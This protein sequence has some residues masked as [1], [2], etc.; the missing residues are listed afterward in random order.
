MKISS[1]IAYGSGAYIVHDMLASN[2]DNYTV[3][4]Y[5]P[6]WTYFPP[7]IHY[8]GDKS[9]DLVHVPIDYAIF[10]RLP[11][12]PLISTF[13]SFVLDEY[14]QPYLS[15]AQKI[16]YKTDLK[17]FTKEALKVSKVVT[18]VSHYLEGM[19]K[20]KLNYDKEIRVIPNGIDTKKFTPGEF[21]GNKIGKIKVLF[22]GNLSRKKGIGFIPEI[23]NHVSSNIELVYT[24]GLRGSN[25]FINH[26]RA[27]SIG[28]IKY[29]DMPSL[30]N[31]VD[32]LLFPT[33]REGFGLAA[34]EAMACGLPIVATDCSALPELVDNKKGGFL[35]LPGD[36]ESFAEKI[37]VLAESPGMRKE[38]GEYNRSKIEKEFTLDRMVNEYKNLFE[39]VLA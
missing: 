23:L 8:F 28:R 1:S 11:G 27:T 18:C 24:A 32:I 22:C 3:Y 20:K 17:W 6:N 21:R 34:A 4:P 29:S 39:E 2:L 30:Y 15:L 10:S 5:H 36:A 35:C 33:V 13:H 38:M 25:K 31:G 9:A 12:K 16:H 26:P 14:L 37:N 7:A 19:I